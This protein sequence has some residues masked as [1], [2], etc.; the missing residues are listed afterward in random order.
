M[1][2]RVTMSIIALVSVACARP[3]SPPS[4]D[5]GAVRDSITAAMGQYVT[6][7]RNNDPAGVT[8]LWADDA[9]YMDAGSP[10]AVGRA[11]FDSVVQGMF[12]TGRLTEVT[13]NTDEIL[14]DHDIAVQRGTYAETLQPQRG[15]P[16]ALRG[17]YL[18]V[19]RRQPDGS[20][21]IARGMGTPNPEPAA[22]R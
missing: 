17:R 19:W 7:L 20:W 1:N 10:T 6:A 16:V 21:K 5:A 8:G 14:V 4:V 2:G 13:E 18:F 3:A 11:A 15:A 9:V 12:S 22:R